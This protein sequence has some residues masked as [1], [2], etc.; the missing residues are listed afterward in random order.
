MAID[1]RPTNEYPIFKK[2]TCNTATTQIQL[3]SSAKSIRIGSEGGIVYV[4]QNGASDT[5]ALPDDFI[6]IGQGDTLEIILGTGPQRR[7]I[8]I[9]SKTGTIDICVMLSE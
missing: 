7:D 3:P 4:C 9:A 2:I 5:G 1:L 8:F 6:F